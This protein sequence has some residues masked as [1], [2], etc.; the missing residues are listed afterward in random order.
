MR[1]DGR[2]ECL[3]QAVSADLLKASLQSKNKT[4]CD[5]IPDVQSDN[6]VRLAICQNVYSIR[7]DTIS[8]RGLI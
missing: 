1:R 3:S 6:P 2:T 7:K 4:N 8:S 5:I